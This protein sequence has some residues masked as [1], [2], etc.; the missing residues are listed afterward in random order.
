VG[1]VIIFSGKFRTQ[2]DTLSSGLT[3]SKV[4]VERF[5]I[6]NTVLKLQGRSRVVSAVRNRTFYLIWLCSARRIIV[7]RSRDSISATSGCR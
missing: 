1:Q 4:R 5:Q 2:N 6:I 7:F 3:K